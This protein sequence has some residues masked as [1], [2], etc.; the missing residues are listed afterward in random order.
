MVQIL[1]QYVQ[2]VD[3]T[4]VLAIMNID[5]SAPASSVYVY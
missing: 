2:Y 3:T 1:Y 5:H 4:L